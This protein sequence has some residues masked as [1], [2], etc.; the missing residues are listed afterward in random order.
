MS[1]WYR[2]ATLTH[3][4]ISPQP[5]NA[6]W[7]SLVIQWLKTWTFTPAQAEHLMVIL[8]AQTRTTRDSDAVGQR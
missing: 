8:R 3:A 6:A 5:V 4:L 1:E 2:V 7:M